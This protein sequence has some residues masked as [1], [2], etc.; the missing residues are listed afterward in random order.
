MAMSNAKEQ[1]VERSP[2]V[3]WLRAGLRKRSWGEL[4]VLGVS[5]CNAVSW[6]EHADGCRNVQVG[7]SPRKY[8][9]MS[10]I[11][12]SVAKSRHR[13][14][15]CLRAGLSTAAYRMSMVH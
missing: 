10:V 11:T 1:K 7:L 9:N 13:D 6:M 3:R 12:V 4:H 8:R 2:L 15:H 5:Y 14:T